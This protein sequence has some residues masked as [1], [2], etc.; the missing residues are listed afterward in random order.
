[1]RN[2]PVLLAVPDLGAVEYGLAKLSNLRVFRAASAA[3][4]EELYTCS[5]PSY[6]VGLLRDVNPGPA[7]SSPEHLTVVGTR[8]F[9]FAADGVHGFELWVSDGTAAGTLRIASLPASGSVA[10]EILSLTAVGSCR[11][12]FATFGGPFGSELW[13]SD[14]TLAGT[15]VVVD[16]YPGVAGGSP[17]GLTA[18]RGRGRNLAVAD[19]R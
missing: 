4:G 1:M 17:Y 18:Y 9:F 7:G 5:G 13:R 2:L 8:L 3:T 14:G 16:L 15:A 12:Y 6:T 19:R 10:P 11:V